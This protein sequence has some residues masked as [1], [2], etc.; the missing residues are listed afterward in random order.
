MMIF[1]V[2]IEHALDVAIESPAEWRMRAELDQAA[3]VRPL[4]SEGRTPK[5]NRGFKRSWQRFV[6][7]A[8]G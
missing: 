1:A 5:Q 7:P 4:V 2:R 6:P 3:H 8:E